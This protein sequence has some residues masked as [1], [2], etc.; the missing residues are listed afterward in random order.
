MTNYLSA[1]TQ[2][3]TN[4]GL[5]EGNQIKDSWALSEDTVT[6]AMSVCNQIEETMALATSAGNQTEDT[7]TLAK[8]EREKQGIT[9][10]WFPNMS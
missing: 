2:M 6:L 8:Q 1:G 3:E 7:A 5:S 9:L 10:I 4:V